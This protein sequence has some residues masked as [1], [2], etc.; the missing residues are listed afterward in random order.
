MVGR[1]R[2]AAQRDVIGSTYFGSVDGKSTSRGVDSRRRTSLSSSAY[3]LM[4]QRWAEKGFTPA[5]G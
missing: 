2:A 1:D 3:V 4:R 5:D